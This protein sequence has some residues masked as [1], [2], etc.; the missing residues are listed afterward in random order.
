MSRRTKLILLGIFLVLLAIPVWHVASNWNSP[1]P[2]RFR[3]VSRE[4]D[5]KYS[6]RVVIE[7][8]NTSTSARCIQSVVLQRVQEPYP[9]FLGVIE[10]G[11]VIP[12]GGTL[13]G[14]T[15]VPLSNRAS[16]EPEALEV[17]YFQASIARRKMLQWYGS[18]LTR[19]PKFQHKPLLRPSIYVESEVTL[20]SSR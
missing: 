1:N 17:T 19:L 15:S 9:P 4:K 7:A 8:R 13:R 5:G 11:P 12:A 20:E 3:L 14:S 10:L 6:E 18:I 2:L 16:T